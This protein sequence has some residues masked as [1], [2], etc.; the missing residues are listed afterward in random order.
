[1]LRIFMLG[2]MFPF[3]AQAQQDRYCISWGPM[4]D[5]ALKLPVWHNDPFI[6]TFGVFAVQGSVLIEGNKEGDLSCLIK[7]G[8]RYDRISYEITDNNYFGIGMYSLTINPQVVLPSR[9][10]FLKFTGGFGIDYLLLGATDFSIT[11]RNV[12]G[13]YYTSLHDMAAK[14][15]PN[16]RR[17]VPYVTL[18]VYLHRL[19]FDKTGRCNLALSVC[20]P[21]V[22]RFVT[23]TALPHLDPD[24]QLYLK[25]YQ[26]TQIGI[27]AGYALGRRR[28]E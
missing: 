17:F 27:A 28:K 12:N 2:L 15:T 23:T 7:G 9:L 8:L 20:Q 6:S 1:M 11:I 19:P 26:P 24:R 21:L 16:L 4:A 14:V 13:Y 25:K 3:A 18:G 22:N 5:V 10:D